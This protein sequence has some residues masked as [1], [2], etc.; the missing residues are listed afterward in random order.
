MRGV[1]GGGSSYLIGMDGGM[2]AGGRGQINFGE[3]EGQA[4]FELACDCF[5]VVC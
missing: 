2:T 3:E 4:W 1:G 5:A